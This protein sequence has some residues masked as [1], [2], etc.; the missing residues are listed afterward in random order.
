MA[1][2]PLPAAIWFCTAAEVV[3]LFVDND[4]VEFILLPD[5]LVE[6]LWLA[7]FGV[8]VFVAAAA[9][10]PCTCFAFV[11]TAFVLEAQAPAPPPPV[12]AYLL[13][14]LPSK[15][16]DVIVATLHVFTCCCDEDGIV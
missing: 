10:V 3:V 5:D 13:D 15:E 6:C 7:S 2:L 1:V 9:L 14:L 12:L 4:E 8:T 11:A 16:D